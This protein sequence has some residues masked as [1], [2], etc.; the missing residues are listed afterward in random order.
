MRIILVFLVL[1]LCGCCHAKNY[2]NEISLLTVLS[3]NTTRDIMILNSHVNEIE[4][5][6]ELMKRENGNTAKIKQ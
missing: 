6:L 5:K 3:S 4:A 2:D 1:Q